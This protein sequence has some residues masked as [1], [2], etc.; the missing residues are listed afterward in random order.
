MSLD[1]TFCDLN[2]I[3][4]IGRL[5]IFQVEGLFESEECSVI[6]FDGFFF[7]IYWKF[8]DQKE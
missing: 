3:V 1:N 8:F 2:V 4:D 7:I 6:I 5:L